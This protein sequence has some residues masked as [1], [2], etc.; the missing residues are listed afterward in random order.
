MNQ[1]ALLP[2]SPYGATTSVRTLHKRSTPPSMSKQH[3]RML[4]VERFFQQSRNKL[5][6]FNVFLVCRK[7]EI[8]CKTRSALLPNGKSVEATFDFVAVD[9]VVPTLLLVWT[10]FQTVITTT[11]TAVGKSESLCDWTY[12]SDRRRSA[13]TCWT[14][15]P[16]PPSELSSPDNSNLR[17]NSHE[18]NINELCRR[19]TTLL[20]LL[21]CHNMRTAHNLVH[22]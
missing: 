5:K 12:P 11:T 15:S 3:C 14:S 21:L 18:D 1:G 16:P 7:D 13:G 17:I 19:V 9:N 2:R 4:Q 6:I 8:S 10:G 20:L 22:E